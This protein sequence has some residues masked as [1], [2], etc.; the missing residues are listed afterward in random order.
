[1]HRFV[2]LFSRALR[3]A[4]TACLASVSLLLLSGC[5][6]VKVKLGWKVYLDK[7]P[8]ASIEV[9]QAK[10][11]GIAPGEKS[12]LIVVVTEPNGKILQTEGAG[13][14]KVLWKDLTV[15]ATVVT[16]N[17]EGVLSLPHDPRKTEGKI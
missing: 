1:M 9:S 13:H 15:T 17:N 10:G 5:T 14:G 7:T 8:I 3:I 16:V 6:S 11:T 2:S 12:P 4:P